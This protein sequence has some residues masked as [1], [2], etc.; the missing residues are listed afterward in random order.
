MS[1]LWNFRFGPF[2]SHLG[3][4]NNKYLLI[5]KNPWVA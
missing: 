4:S 5:L 2:G 1:Y 3:A